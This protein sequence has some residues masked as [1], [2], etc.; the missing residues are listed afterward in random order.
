MKFEKLIEKL[1]VSS[2]GQFGELVLSNGESIYLELED[3][4]SENWLF[5]DATDDTKDES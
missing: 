4:D 5:R 2:D 1:K 3:I